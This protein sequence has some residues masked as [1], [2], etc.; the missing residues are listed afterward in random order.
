LASRQPL[1]CQPYF[2]RPRYLWHALQPFSPDQTKEQVGGKGE[3]APFIYRYTFGHPEATSW[4]F[5]AVKSLE[6]QQ[7]RELGA[8]ELEAEYTPY[9]VDR[10]NEELS[11]ERYL[12]TVEE[13]LRA[14]IEELAPLRMFN[15]SV[16]AQLLPA[17]L[18]AFRRPAIG[19]DAL[20]IIQE[21][22]RTRLVSWDRERRGYVIE[23]PLRQILA[24]LLEKDRPAEYA[25]VQ[26]WAADEYR[27]WAE[28][29]PS[30]RL[31]A[32]VETLYHQALILKELKQVEDPVSELK[33]MLK[34]MI[35]HY[36]KQDNKWDEVNIDELWQQLHTDEDLE[37]LLGMD[38]VEQLLA[39]LR[40]SK[41]RLEA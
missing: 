24:R 13:H 10:L 18:E 28:N 27:S 26:Q 39:V 21:M 32:I 37:S 30:K 11:Q 9:I 36:D 23:N 22:A 31:D 12:G 8:A 40:P 33:V 17:R 19:A 1:D 20:A 41:A 14:A 29:V 7:H 16:I 15:V 6:E 5:K 2:L 25:F 38:G 34:E 4:I 3:L 35:Q